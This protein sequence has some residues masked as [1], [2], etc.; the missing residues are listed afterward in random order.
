MRS[1]SL[2][3]LPDPRSLP[4]LSCDIKPLSPGCRLCLPLPR[5]G[6]RTA[7]SVSSCRGGWAAGP[8]TGFWPTSTPSCT[9]WNT[10]PGSPERQGMRET[11]GRG[12][13]DRAERLPQ[14]G[15]GF[16]D[17]PTAPGTQAQPSGA[18]LR[19]MAGLCRHRG[20]PSPG[21]LPR[22]SGGPALGIA[23][24]S[25]TSLDSAARP[26]ALSATVESEGGERGRQRVSSRG[27]RDSPLRV[28]AY[29][30]TTPDWASAPTARQKGPPRAALWCWPLA[31]MPSSSRWVA[32]APRPPGGL[33]RDAPLFL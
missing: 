24:L 32:R 17:S 4:R 8:S 16:R 31:A 11:K 13:G 21:V 15:P 29:S 30:S 28:S 5:L 18:S 9:H 22:P 27:G 26:W 7:W 1:A 6:S 20:A 33:C 25:L 23:G 3:L 14:S 10:G 2:S 19:G 12:G